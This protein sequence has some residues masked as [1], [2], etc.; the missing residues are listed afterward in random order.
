MHIIESRCRYDKDLML[1]RR[2]ELGVESDVSVS[3]MLPLPSHSIRSSIRLSSSY[4][5]E[6]A[7]LRSIKQ[8][9]AGQATVDNRFVPWQWNIL[10][11]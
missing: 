8:R 1:T 3:C 6:S 10:S 5:L 7:H 2:T 9:D 4:Q 11:F